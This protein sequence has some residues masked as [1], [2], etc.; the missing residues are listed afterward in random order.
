MSFQLIAWALLSFQMNAS[1]PIA[2]DNDPQLRL[3]YS[4]S[5]FSEHACE[6]VETLH[7]AVDDVQVTVTFVNTTGREVTLLHVNKEGR[8]ERKADLQ[9]GESMTIVTHQSHVWTVRNDRNSCH[10]LLKVS[11]GAAASETVTFAER[12]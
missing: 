1:A 10:T 9:A 8:E 11:A 3:D 12:Q 2:A 5:A 4:A 6:E 7:S